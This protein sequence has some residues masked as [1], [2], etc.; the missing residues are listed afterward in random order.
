MDKRTDLPDAIASLQDGMTIGIG[1]WGPRRKPMALIREILRSD[2][3]D[4]HLVCY[5]GPEVGMLCAAGKVSKLTY[6]FVS[7]DKIPLEPWYRKARENGT[8][9]VN[10][11]DEG[12]LLLGLRAAAERVPFA[13]TRVGLGSSVPEINSYMKTVASPYDPN[14][15]LLA[16]PAIPLDVSLIHVARADR[17]GNTRSEGPD[18]FFDDLFAGAAERVIVSAE[19]VVDRLDQSDA[20]DAKK[21]LFHRGLVDK[22]VAAPLGAHPTTSHGHYGWDMEHLKLYG[23]TA[24]DTAA[25]AE[26]NDR[27]VAGGEAAYV[28]ALGGAEAI[29]KLPIPVF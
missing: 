21:S 20:E 16:M 4:L 23:A 12:L 26:Y 1:G 8:V 9:S 2:L 14:D 17:M 22:V 19:E 15:I 24:G 3:K 25:W 7:L 6:G 10:E 5:G 11:L 29:L 27:Y 18:P 13:P 28:N